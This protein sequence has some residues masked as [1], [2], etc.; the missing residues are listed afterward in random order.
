MHLWVTCRSSYDC[1]NDIGEL[2]FLRL[3][4]ELKTS[5]E[6][7]KSEKYKVITDMPY[8]NECESLLL[9]DNEKIYAENIGGEIG[10]NLGLVDA[11][12][13]DIEFHTKKNCSLGVLYIEEDRNSIEDYAIKQITNYQ[14]KNRGQEYLISFDS[15][16]N[17]FDIIFSKKFNSQWKLYDDKQNIIIPKK[18]FSLV[19]GYHIS[20]PTDSVTLVFEP[21]KSFDIG[22]GVASV[23]LVS[24]FGYLGYSGIRSYRR[25]KAL[26]QS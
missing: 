1:T 25:R 13:H 12:F 8:S 11:G 23:A 4:S 22:L 9:F 5:L 17:N 19:N 3:N 26:R 15:A 2:S 24:C 14:I 6:F 21:S 10:F 7:I 20:N 18:L 16:E